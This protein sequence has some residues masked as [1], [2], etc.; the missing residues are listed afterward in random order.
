MDDVDVDAACEK[1]GGRGNSAVVLEKSN[2]LM[3]GGAI[4]VEF[5]L[6]ARSLPLDGVAVVWVAF[7]LARERLRELDLM[8]LIEFDRLLLEGA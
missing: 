5:E 4:I 3:G 6:R 7:E 8:V 2:T 1:N